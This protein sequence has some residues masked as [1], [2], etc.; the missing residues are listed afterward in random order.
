MGRIGRKRKLR[1]AIFYAAAAFVLLLLLM[2]RT[3]VWLAL[4]GVLNTAAQTYDS[5]AG[6]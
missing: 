5:L 4:V 2:Y 3:S 6:R 1:T